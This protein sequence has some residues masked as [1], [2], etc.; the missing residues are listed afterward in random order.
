[1]QYAAAPREYTGKLPVASRVG[2]PIPGNLH[3][4]DKFLL[5]R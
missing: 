2:L 4:S 1:M 3:A 5:D